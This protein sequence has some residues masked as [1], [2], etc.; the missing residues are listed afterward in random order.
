LHEGGDT[1]LV[2]KVTPTKGRRTYDVLLGDAAPFDGAGCWY[3][4]AGYQPMRNLALAAALLRDRELE[5]A[6][7]V[8]CAP[9]A[10]VDLRADLA[11]ISTSLP[12]LST[13]WLNAEEVF[14]LHRHSDSAHLSRRYDLRHE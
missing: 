7:F 13:G 8:V 12:G 14:S 6:V 10:R 1:A 5:Q 11:R 2:F 9:R 3:R 4:T